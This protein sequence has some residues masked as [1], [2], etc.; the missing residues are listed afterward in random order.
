MIFS[1]YA[2]RGGWRLVALFY[3]GRK[4][5]KLLD[6][7]TFDIHRISVSELDGLCPVDIRP[8]AAA[9]RMAQ[10]RALL[11][12]CNVDFPKKSVQAAIN[13]LRQGGPGQ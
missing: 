3:K 10:R 12:R 5:A 9:R 6:V 2:D 4:W 11:K 13:A 7:S 1:Y 8:R